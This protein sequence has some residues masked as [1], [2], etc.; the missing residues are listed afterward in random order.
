[1]YALALFAHPLRDTH[2]LLAKHQLLLIHLD[3]LL[4]L[5]CICRALL[6]VRV[7]VAKNRECGRSP[8]KL[9]L[10]QALLGEDALA[11]F[12]DD[13]L[14]LELGALE[15]RGEPFRSGLL[16]ELLPPLVGETIRLC[17]LQLFEDRLELECSSD[18]AICWEAK[19]SAVVLICKG[20]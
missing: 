13:A 14:H 15:Q 16:L 10:A 8:V 3:V 4:I 11:H 17:V 9:D 2:V 20:A 7:N 1:M 6:D 12:P 5:L 19:V 18:G